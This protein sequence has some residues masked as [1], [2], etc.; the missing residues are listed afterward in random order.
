[1]FTNLGDP[2]IAQGWNF[3]RN[4]LVMVGDEIVSQN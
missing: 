4:T 1:M 2:A 3:M